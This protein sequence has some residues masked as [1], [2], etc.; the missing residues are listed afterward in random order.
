VTRAAAGGHGNGWWRWLAGLLA[1]LLPLISLVSC[2]FNPL[3]PPTSTLMALAPFPTLEISHPT[4]LSP[5]SN[6]SPSPTPTIAFFSLGQ[7]ARDQQ[8]LLLANS[9]PVWPT[10]PSPGFRASEADLL[11]VP[12]MPSA[13][14]VLEWRPPPV[15]VPHSLHPHDHYW[16]R[17]PI[18]SGRVDYGLD[19]YPYGGNGGGAWRLHHGM[20]FPN[21]PGTPVL[22]TASGVVVWVEDNW[23]PIYVPVEEDDMGSESAEGMLAEAEE[24]AEIAVTA[25]SEVTRTLRLV[26]PYGNYVIVKH[27]WGWQGEPVYTLYGHLLEVFVQPGDHVSA[28][29]LLGGVGNTG[30]STGPH[31]HFE[32]R[33]GSN[34]YG[35]TRN[36]AL[37]IAPYEG[38]GNLAGLIATSRGTP[39]PNIVVSLYP[40]LPG[41]QVD[42]QHGRFLG[43]YAG[44]QVHPDEY[45]NENFFLPDL[46]AGQYQVVARA[47]GE[48]LEATVEIRAGVTSFVK[49]HTS[50]PYL[51]PPPSTPSPTPTPDITTTPSP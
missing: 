47:A 6:L 5:S 28:G 32:V 3:V 4:A 33:I 27:D 12:Q 8:A 7:V 21:D 36:P 18:P 29:D 30:N 14:E 23:T 24:P 11:F 15:P 9:P 16:L 34:G 17:R 25:E 42:F 13:A 31:L 43:T 37:W 22:A 38:W 20:D 40:V 35:Y 44:W 45:R 41:G 39:I 46:P 2:D 26:G 50:S 49:L 10:S 1:C 51:P 48:I 19:W